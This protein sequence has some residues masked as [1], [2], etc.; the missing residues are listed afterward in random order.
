M[1]YY[2]DAPEPPDLPDRLVS[3]ESLRNG[4]GYSKTDYVA[5]ATGDLYTG[6][7]KGV[8]WGVCCENV[9]VG[10]GSAI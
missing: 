10:N 9:V 4:L 7:D 3:W 8:I 6:Y 2:R 1:R 5:V